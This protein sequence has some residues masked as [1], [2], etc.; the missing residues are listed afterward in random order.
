MSLLRVVAIAHAPICMANAILMFGVQSQPFSTFCIHNNLR[1]AYQA[2][3]L[4]KDGKS[5]RVG[6]DTRM[7]EETALQRE[8]GGPV[9]VCKV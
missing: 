1:V 7:F 2:V 4:M 6:S 8:K 5:D 9:L 3:E